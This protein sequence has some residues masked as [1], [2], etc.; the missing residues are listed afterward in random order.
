ML[1]HIF[2]MG[3]SVYYLYITFCCYHNIS[4]DAHS[5]LQ[6]DSHTR[7]SFYYAEGGNIDV[8]LLTSD[9]LSNI[10][11]DF[12]CIYVNLN[13]HIMHRNPH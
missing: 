13:I 2:D 8:I 9:S 3:D 5:S 11:S 7:Y 1:L 4:A 6:Q 10:L 12:E